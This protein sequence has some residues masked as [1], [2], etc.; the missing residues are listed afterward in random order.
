MKW[1]KKIKI[2]SIQLLLHFTCKASYEYAQKEER[3]KEYWIYFLFNLY[4]KIFVI[5]CFC[6]CLLFAREN[7]N[8]NEIVSV[9]YLF[10][11]LVI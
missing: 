9:H 4:K 10:T 11:N 6:C 5:L 8:T 2:I 1:N 7:N 3:K